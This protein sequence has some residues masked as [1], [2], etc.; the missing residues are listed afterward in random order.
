MNEWISVDERL[1]E[2]K[3]RYLMMVN[4]VKPS[5]L[6]GE[7]VQNNI[8][9]TSNFIPGKGWMSLCDMQII[10]H[11]MEIPKLKEKENED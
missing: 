7:T 10:T 9:F 6:N 4:M 11:W 8:A 5:K 1:P 3:G 2:K